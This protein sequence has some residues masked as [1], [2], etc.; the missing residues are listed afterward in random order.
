MNQL[1]KKKPNAN[2]KPHLLKNLFIFSPAII[3]FIIIAIVVLVWAPGQYIVR[4]GV[5]V[6]PSW[7]RIWPTIIWSLS[8]LAIFLLMLLAK[9]FLHM[10]AKKRQD[11]QSFLLCMIVTIALSVSVVIAL[12]GFMIPYMY[13]FFTPYFLFLY[14]AWTLYIV[15]SIIIAVE[16]GKKYRALT[17][18]TKEN[19]HEI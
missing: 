7:R 6:G 9:F 4:N 15:V 19:T 16:N 12:G 14:A 2:C 10:R 1:D 17:S 8:V 3:C 11:K 13:F 5:R 18:K